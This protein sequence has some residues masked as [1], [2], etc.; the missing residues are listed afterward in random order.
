MPST[1]SLDRLQMAFA[2]LMKAAL[3]GA[4]VGAALDDVELEDEPPHAP[5]TSPAE[6]PPIS[7][8]SRTFM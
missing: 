7:T 2:R 6:H 5:R 4:T 1:W 3:P 8:A